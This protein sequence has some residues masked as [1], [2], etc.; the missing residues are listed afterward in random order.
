MYLVNA[1][2]NKKKKKNINRFDMMSVIIINL[3]FV[4]DQKFTKQSITKI[5]PL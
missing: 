3:I 1:T 4:V 5:I 2:I